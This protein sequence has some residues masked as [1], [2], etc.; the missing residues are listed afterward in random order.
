MKTC[1]S[2]KETKPFEEF[3]P[4]KTTSTWT[5][6]CRKC[7]CIRIRQWGID[8]PGVRKKYDKAYRDRQTPE[9]KQKQKEQIKAWEAAHKDKRREYDKRNYHK[10][11]AQKNERRKQLRK[12]NPLFAVACRLRSRLKRALKNKTKTSSAIRD[13]GCSY[14]YLLKHLNDSCQARYGE[15]YVGNEEKYHIDHI[16]PLSSFDLGDPGQQAQAIHYTNLQI[17]SRLDNQKKGA[18]CA[19]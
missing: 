10:R 13:V 18:K 9:Q 19:E 14:D 5:A 12:E 2:C 3:Y 17:L 7:T 4:I 15:D 1:T 16:R 11:K 6:R 8:N